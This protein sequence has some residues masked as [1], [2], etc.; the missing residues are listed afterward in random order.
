MFVRAAEEDLK[1][2]PLFWTHLCKLVRFCRG[3]VL[4]LWTL[5]ATFVDLSFLSV[6]ALHPSLHPSLIS[7]LLTH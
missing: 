5:A 1:G 6:L 3:S 7:L 4:P 2:G